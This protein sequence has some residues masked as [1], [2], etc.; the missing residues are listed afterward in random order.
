MNFELAMY[1]GIPNSVAALEG[2]Y[3]IKTD[4]DGNVTGTPN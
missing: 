1:M 3:L 4:M 2:V